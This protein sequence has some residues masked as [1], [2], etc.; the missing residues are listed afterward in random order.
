MDTTPRAAAVAFGIRL[1]VA[2]V[3]WM[4]AEAAIALI[5]ALM[6]KSVLLAAFGFDS[7]IELLSGLLLLWRLSAESRGADIKRI[8]RTEHSAARVAAALLILLCAFVVVTSAAGLVIGLK[9]EGSLLG[10]AVAG[11]A[12]VAMPL[13][14]VGKSRANR[15]I[16]SASLR[17]DIAE[18]ITCA[19]MAGVTLL[20]VALSMLPGLW[21][22]Q[23]LCALALLIW[24]VPE[25]REALEA[26]RETH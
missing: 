17:A 14:A 8:E 16:G 3:A 13:L 10:I 1:E 26:A 15:L 22:I 19:Y 9:P 6:A 5:A 20:G 23:Y 18:T 21:W 12:V 11:V 25:T 24:L 2:P 7:V 4:A